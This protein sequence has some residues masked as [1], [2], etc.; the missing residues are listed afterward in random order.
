MSGVEYVKKLEMM[1]CV[2]GGVISVKLD[3]ER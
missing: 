3:V 1:V 2:Y